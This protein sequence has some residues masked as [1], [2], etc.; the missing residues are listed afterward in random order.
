[1]WY[2]DHRGDGDGPQAV[3]PGHVRQ[4]GVPPSPGTMSRR[5][6]PGSPGDRCRSCHS[7]TSSAAC[8]G[9]RRQRYRGFAGGATGPARRARDGRPRP[10]RQARVLPHV[11]SCTSSRHDLKLRL[12]AGASPSGQ[13]SGYPSGRDDGRVDLRR[14][15]DDLAQAVLLEALEGRR[16]D[17]PETLRARRQHEVLER[18]GHRDQVVEVRRPPPSR[19]GSRGGPAGRGSRPGRCGRCPSPARR[20]RA[21]TRRAPRRSR[22]SAGRMIPK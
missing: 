14:E 10:G 2:V 12:S 5:S 3:D 7:S 16:R 9:G 13:A 6:R 1:M 4:A 17:R 8:V 19:A 11:S 20:S 21:P 15:A 18:E 22:P